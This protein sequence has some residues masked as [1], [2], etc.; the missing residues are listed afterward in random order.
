M[1]PSSP[2]VQIVLALYEALGGRF[3]DLLAGDFALAMY[4]PER[5]VVLLG[6]DA[7]EVRPIHYYRGRGFIIFASE[8]K[9]ILPILGWN[10]AERRSDRPWLLTGWPPGATGDVL[11]RC[12]LRS[13]F[14]YRLHRTGQRFEAAVLGLRYRRRDPVAGLRGVRGGV[15]RAVRNRGHTAHAE[16]SPRRDIPLGR[17]RLLFDREL[18]RSGAQPERGHSGGAGCLRVRTRGLSV[19][20]AGVRVFRRGQMVD[21]ARTSRDRDRLVGHGSDTAW[22]VE[23][24]LG[25]PVPNVVV[26]LLAASRDRGARMILTGHWGDQFVADTTYFVDLARRFRWMKLLT[27]MLERRRWTLDED[28]MICAGVRSKPRDRLRTRRDAAVPSEVPNRRVAS[29]A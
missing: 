20:R 22:A 16:R 28:P 8:I 19:R 10:L 23:C 2:D 5:G 18:R 17:A 3:I 14:A 11:P 4:D 7:L 26:D 27:R 24:P 1:E 15:P 29:G 13:A 6:R 25:T 9:A 21:G 12:L